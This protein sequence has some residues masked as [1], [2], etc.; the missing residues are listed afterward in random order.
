MVAALLGY[1]LS[2]GT[3]YSELGAFVMPMPYATKQTRREERTYNVVARP[4]T[5][6]FRGS[7]VAGAVS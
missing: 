5:F 4:M 3:V 2:D 7:Y 1:D 6:F